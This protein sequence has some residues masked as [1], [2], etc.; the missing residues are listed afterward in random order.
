MGAK[1]KLTKPE[2]GTLSN[3]LRE[4][5]RMRAKDIHENAQYWTIEQLREEH[6]KQLQAI[7]RLKDYH[8]E[9]LTP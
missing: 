1:V 4:Q 7:D 6:T 5:I 8:L 3:A 2:I 9:A